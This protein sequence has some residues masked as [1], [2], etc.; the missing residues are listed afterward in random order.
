MK[1]TYKIKR[2]FAPSPK[3]VL[4]DCGRFQFATCLSYK[5]GKESIY[6][7]FEWFKASYRFEHDGKVYE[8]ESV[9]CAIENRNGDL[10]LWRIG[11][12]WKSADDKPAD[13]EITGKIIKEYRWME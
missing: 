5:P 6:N 7:W 10:I 1:T 4:E 13:Q 11:P 3:G 12:R 8:K 9:P 2:K